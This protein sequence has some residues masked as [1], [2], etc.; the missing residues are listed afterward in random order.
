MN[1]IESWTTFFGWC[2]VINGGAYLLTVLGLMLAPSLV[3]RV[4][5]WIFGIDERDV[6]REAFAYVGRYKLA[7]MLLCFAPWLALKLMA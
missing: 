5:S 7:I 6:R 2:T 1:S 4:N 3:A